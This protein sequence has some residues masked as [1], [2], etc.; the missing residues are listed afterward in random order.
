MGYSAQLEA[1]SWWIEVPS[2]LMLLFAAA[3]VTLAIL[4]VRDSRTASTRPFAIAEYTPPAGLNVM[5]AAH[6]V[7][8]SRSA[9]PAQLL[10]L[11]INKN[12]RLVDRSLRRGRQAFAAKFITA[13]GA[14]EIGVQ[15]LHAIF[16]SQPTAGELVEMRADNWE[17]QLDVARVSAAASAI[18]SERGWRQ[19]AVWSQWANLAGAVALQVAAFLGVFYYFFLDLY[20]WWFVAVCVLAPVTLV[21]SLLSM[22]LYGP[23]TESGAQV[24]D[25]LEGLRTYL[26]LAESDRLRMLQ[27]VD[28]AQRVRGAGAV[29]A[30]DVYEKLLP[31]AVIWGVERSWISD[32]IGNAVD[33]D[34]APRWI[35]DI[36]HLWVLN[37]I[38]LMQRWYR[39]HAI[40]MGPRRIRIVRIGAPG[41]WR[42]RPPRA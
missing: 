10:L 19:G 42:P 39:A 37:L 16:G 35:S 13:E 6:L 30:I 34:V 36:N 4:R 17:L 24:R 29:V 27:G 32:L 33:L 38:A 15:M 28:S 23:L 18:P 1:R 8:R 2:I 22:R 9:V 40:P 7:G 41:T 12:I 21:V 31:Y 5:A 11:A 3:L 25:H 26:E 14:D 20:S